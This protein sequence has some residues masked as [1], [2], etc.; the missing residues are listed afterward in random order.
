M[1]QFEFKLWLATHYKRGQKQFDRLLFLAHFGEVAESCGATPIND[2]TLNNWL[3]EGRNPPDY[4]GG[5]PFEQFLELVLERKNN[6][7]P[8]AAIYT[9]QIALSEAENQALIETAQQAEST[10]EDFLRLCL[11]IGFEDEC[12]IE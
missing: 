2:S 1:T 12:G 7:T 3:T 10:P 4:Y 5:L 6:P 8:P 9:V 11:R